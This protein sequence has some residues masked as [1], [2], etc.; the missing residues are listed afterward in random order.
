MESL[1]S[2]DGSLIFS[3]EKV[4]RDFAQGSVAQRAVCNKRAGYKR[5]RISTVSGS[6]VSRFLI[7]VLR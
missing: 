3:R 7:T 6:A 2:S 4:F 1:V 5:E